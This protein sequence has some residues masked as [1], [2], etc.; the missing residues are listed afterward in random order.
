MHHPR[1]CKSSATPIGVVTI[2]LRPV[3]LCVLNA[4]APTDTYIFSLV[5][6]N[7]MIQR[8]RMSASA[9]RESVMDDAPR[10]RCKKRRARDEN[11][12]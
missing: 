1:R 4:T 3:G 7:I 6:M 8:H 11:E 2:E 5:S 10:M 9:G 12:I